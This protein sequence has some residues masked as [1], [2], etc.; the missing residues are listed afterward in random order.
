VLT[1][2][3][4]IEYMTAHTSFTRLILHISN[5]VSLYLDQSYASPLSSR[6]FWEL[7][8]D[9][10]VENSCAPGRLDGYSVLPYRGHSQQSLLIIRFLINAAYMTILLMLIAY[11][12]RENVIKDSVLCSKCS[13]L[14]SLH[15]RSPAMISN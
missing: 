4:M 12:A 11:G 14:K 7:G 6:Q 13:E 1:F 9:D 10:R 8:Y 2:I 5:V 3:I 15:Y